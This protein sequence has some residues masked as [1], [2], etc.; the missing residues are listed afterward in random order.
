M[1]L[2]AGRAQA[3]CRP[4]STYVPFL[5]PPNPPISLLLAIPPGG[6]VALNPCEVFILATAPPILTPDIKPEDRLGFIGDIPVFVATSSDDCRSRGPAVDV[7]DPEPN[8]RLELDREVEIWCADP[9]A[10]DEIW[11]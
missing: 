7:A 3:A 6:L 4:K 9:R 5:A 2:I 10:V 11:V 8:L 1:Y